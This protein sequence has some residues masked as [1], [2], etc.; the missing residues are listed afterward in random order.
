[1]RHDYNLT[2]SRRGSENFFTGMRG[3]FL[4]QE[5][6]RCSHSPKLRVRLATSEV[7]T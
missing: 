3:L 5:T 6:P 7:K 1:M 2:R 4:T